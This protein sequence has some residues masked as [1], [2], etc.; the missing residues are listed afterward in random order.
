MAVAVSTEESHRDT[1]AVNPQSGATGLM[2]IHPGGEQYKDPDTNMRTAVAK[3]KA[4]GWQPWSVCGAHAWA[5]GVPG[6][7]KL[8]AKANAVARR[9]KAPRP[10]Q[11]IPAGLLGDLTK[12]PWIDALEDLGGLDVTPDLPDPGDITSLPGKALDGVKTVAVAIQDIF[13][14]IASVLA[15]LADP[16]TWGDLLKIWI[17]LWLLYLGVKRTFELTK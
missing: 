2:Q 1:D 17:G 13:R 5:A 16:N 3:W 6:C 4:R 12:N 8:A 10:G 15:K 11:P 9:I 7:P 14:L